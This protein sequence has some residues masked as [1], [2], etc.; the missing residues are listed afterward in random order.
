MEV[1]RQAVLVSRQA[2]DAAVAQAAALQETI[3]AMLKSQTTS[4]AAVETD[5]ADVR[6]QHFESRGRVSRRDA[7][8]T[9][10]KEQLTTTQEMYAVFDEKYKDAVA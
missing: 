5:L 7:E 6:A 4:T 2:A 1:E 9:W 3:D 10:L 8:I